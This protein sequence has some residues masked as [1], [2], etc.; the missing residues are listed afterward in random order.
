MAE[1]AIPPCGL[2]RT[3]ADIGEIRAGRL[4]YFHNHGD[5][6]PGIFLPSAWQ[7]NRAQFRD[8]GQQIDNAEAKRYLEPLP[9]EG[10]YRVLEEFH[11]CAKKC[12]LFYD[13]MLVQLGYD[14]AAAP[15]LFV[16]EW[17]DSGLEIPTQGI[18][19]DRERLAKIAPLRV[20]VRE[21]NES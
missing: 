15:I 4:V 6:G 2:Y 20:A 5:P 9:A 8:T 16:P 14:D 1:D 12:Q 13:E 11:C 17:I 3:V 21:T 10:F 7:G 19:V 18:G